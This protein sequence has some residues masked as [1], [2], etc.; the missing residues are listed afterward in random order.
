MPREEFRLPRWF[1]RSDGLNAPLLEALWT[2]LQRTDPDRAVA[3]LYLTRAAGKHLDAHGLLYG[4]ARRTREP[5]DAYRARIL[6][7]VLNPRS[8]AD[9]I[10]RVIE[11]TMPPVTATVIPPTPN[12]N[13]LTFDGTWR[14]NSTEFF[15]TKFAGVN[16]ALFDVLI[17]GEGSPDLTEARDLIENIRAA[18]YIPTVTTEAGTFDATLDPDDGI[19]GTSQEMDDPSFNGFRDFDGTWTFG[20]SPAGDPVPL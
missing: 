7:R 4:V 1:E 12:T 14:F 6:A 18:G 9:A 3:M 20:V 2:G 17:E 11:R 8:T 13:F 16:L 19:S 5:D 10:E 15:I